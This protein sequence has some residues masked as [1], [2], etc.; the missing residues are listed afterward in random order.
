[1]VIT[2]FLLISAALHWLFFSIGVKRSNRFPEKG[3]RAPL[4]ASRE[5]VMLHCPWSWNT[6]V[7]AR[8]AHLRGIICVH[9]R[10]H[11]TLGLIT[12]EDL[13][14][15]ALHEKLAR[16][17]F[18]SRLQFWGIAARNFTKSAMIVAIVVVVFF[19]LIGR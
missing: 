16:H 8:I 17:C 1:M 11:E 7:R 4:Y 6:S 3:W 13:D 14:N 12:R 10:K 9:G 2:W 15:P 18:D 5:N 19:L